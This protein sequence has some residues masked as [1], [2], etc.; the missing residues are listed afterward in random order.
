MGAAT[1]ISSRLI[2]ISSGAALEHDL[3]VFHNIPWIESEYGRD[4]HALFQMCFRLA[5]VV[6]QRLPIEP[7]DTDGMSISGNTRPAAFQLGR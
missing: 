2:L 1:P 5:G 3:K 6:A 4:A 7:R